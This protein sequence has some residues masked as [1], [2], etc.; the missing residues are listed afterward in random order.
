MI[1]GADVARHE[2]VH[3][4]SPTDRGDAGSDGVSAADQQ[5]GWRRVSRLDDDIITADLLGRLQEYA[6]DQIVPG[7]QVFDDLGITDRMFW[8]YDSVHCEG[9]AHSCR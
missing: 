8:H 5:Y 2:N 4:R 7:Q 3:D 6:T 1:R 9:P